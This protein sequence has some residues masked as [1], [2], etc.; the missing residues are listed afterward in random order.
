MVALLVLAFAPALWEQAAGPAPAVSLRPM[1]L[2]RLA[3]PVYGSEHLLLLSRAE[4][5]EPA[6][7]SHVLPVL[8][9]FREGEQLEALDSGESAPSAAIG[10]E[11]AARRRLFQAAASRPLGPWDLLKLGDG[12]ASFAEALVRFI[13]RNGWTPDALELGTAVE[14]KVRYREEVGMR[15]MGMN[16]E[17]APSSVRVGELEAVLRCRGSQGEL[18]LALGAG[19]ALDPSTPGL[20]SH[21]LLAAGWPAA[22]PEPM[23]RDSPP[24]RV[25]A[26]RCFWLSLRAC[27]S[28]RQQPLGRGAA[29]RSN[30]CPRRSLGGAATCAM[31]SARNSSGWAPPNTCAF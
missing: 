4:T 14:G 28:R 18:A 24:Q 17:A 31:P 3:L 27:L 22:V 25:R 30:E 21:R 9:R 1:R 7:L 12:C 6:A 19:L 15:D 8:L 16:T 13:V 26:R 5:T 23:D 29:A 10:I 2:S 11:I 20:P